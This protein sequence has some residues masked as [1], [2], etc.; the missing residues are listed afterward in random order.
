[1]SLAGLMRTGAEAV[2]CPV[3]VAAEHLIAGRITTPPQPSVETRPTTEEL[4]F[5]VTIAGDVVKIKKDKAGLAAA[6]TAYPAVGGQDIF[7]QPIGVA[8]PPPPVCGHGSFTGAAI[9][10]GATLPEIANGDKLPAGGTPSR[11]RRPYLGLDVDPAAPS[12]VGLPGDFA[13]VTVATEPAGWPLRE[14][15]D[16]FRGFAPLTPA[17]AIWNRMDLRLDSARSAVGFLASDATGTAWP[18]ELASPFPCAAPLKL[19]HRLSLVAG[20]TVPLS[21]HISGTIAHIIHVVNGL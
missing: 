15:P 8:S 2:L 17:H 7:P 9:G 3:A 10:P 21:V 14:L 11:P 1:M 5:G 13:R 16:R 19:C 12:F 18:N 4:P 6:D 20:V